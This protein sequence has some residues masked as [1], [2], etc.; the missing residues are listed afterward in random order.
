PFRTLMS[1]FAT[2]FGEILMVP[3]M[4]CVPRGS[5]SDKAENCSMPLAADPKAICSDKTDPRI[6]SSDVIKRIAADSAH[7][8]PSGI[9]IIGAVFCH[10][11]HLVW[12][13]LPC[14]RVLDRSPVAGRR[15]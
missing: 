3:S 12:L 6:L 7:I 2:G 14:S 10:P 9:R 5:G 1:C 8:A 13:D 4:Q 15:T 11:L